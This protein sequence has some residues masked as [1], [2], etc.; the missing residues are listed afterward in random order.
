[1][2]RYDKTHEDFLGNIYRETQDNSC[3][4]NYCNN[5]RSI[6]SQIYKPL[7]FDPEGG[8]VYYNYCKLYKT[9]VYDKLNMAFENH[10]HSLAP[11]TTDW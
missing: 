6:A 10:E 9:T 4:L 11:A 3:H 8:S 1:M 5:A 2:K 7:D